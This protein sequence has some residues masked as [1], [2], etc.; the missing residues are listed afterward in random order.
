MLTEAQ[1]LSGLAVIEMAMKDLG[2]PIVSGS[3]VSAAQDWY[4]SAFSAD[5]QASAAIGEPV[6]EDVA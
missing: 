4:R 1:A 3:G 5:P 2:Y 6:C